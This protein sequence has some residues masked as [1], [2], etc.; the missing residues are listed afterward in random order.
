MYVS[1][2]L[3]KLEMLMILDLKSIIN[4]QNNHNL[5]MLLIFLMRSDLLRKEIW[6]N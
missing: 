1:K 6:S 3:V 4:A 2:L 5:K